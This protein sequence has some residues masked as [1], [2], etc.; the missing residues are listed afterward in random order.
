MN[1]RP[2]IDRLLG[3]SEPE[4]GCD[5]C[6]EELDRFV[7]AELGGRFQPCPDCLA[8]AGCGADR[9]CV[10]MRAHLRG[11]PACAEEYASLVAVVSAGGPP[12]TPPPAAG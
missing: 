12:P 7:E 3:P 9:G 2:A 10:G 8:P 4:F 5:R 6:F 1:P 11:C